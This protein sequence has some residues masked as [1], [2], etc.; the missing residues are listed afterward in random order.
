MHQIEKWNF[1]NR[2]S[3][4]ISC[5]FNY[6]KFQLRN[7]E[8]TCIHKGTALERGNGS[9]IFVHLYRILS[10]NS[11]QFVEVLLLNSSIDI[12]LFSMWIYWCW[13]LLPFATFVL[14][15]LFFF[16]HHRL[17]CAMRIYNSVWFTLLHSW[18]LESHSSYLY[19]SCSH[20]VF[21]MYNSIF[22]DINWHIEHS[23]LRA[24]IPI[25]INVN[26]IP[27]R[28]LS[29][30][31]RNELSSN[32]LTCD[33]IAQV[34]ISFWLFLPCEILYS[35]EWDRVY[36]KWCRSVPMKQEREWERPNGLFNVQ[37]KIPNW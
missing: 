32:R 17:L 36:K 10:R 37:D 33:G 31:Q 1:S 18:K 35:V 2:V 23:H 14:S 6:F 21:C 29:F 7:T 30:R 26:S 3:G 8:D 5:M 16:L 12:L 11:R 27:N 22:K 20:C 13:L 28:H 15:I 24:S 34:K 25:S 4:R 19:F 9:W